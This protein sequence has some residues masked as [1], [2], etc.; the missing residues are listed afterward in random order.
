[1]TVGWFFLVFLGVVGVFLMF[2]GV[3]VEFFC[4][5]GC[6]FLFFLVFLGVFFGCFWGLG[7]FF[8]FLSVWRCFGRVLVLVFFGIGSFGWEP[9]MHVLLGLCFGSWFF[10]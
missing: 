2:L 4:V 5:L 6:V 1:M 7:C 8:C 10:F 9:G 3:F